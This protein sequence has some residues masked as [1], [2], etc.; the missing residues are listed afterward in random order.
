[1]ARVDRPADKKEEALRWAA[2][3]PPGLVEEHVHRLDN[4]Y[5]IQFSLE[6][7]RFHLRRIAALGKDEMLSLELE[8]V[9]DGAMLLTL[10]ADDLP[11]FFSS[12]SGI[13]TSLDFDIRS[14]KVF[15][16]DPLP[17]GATPRPGSRNLILD[18]LVLGHP[19]AGI[20]TPAFKEVLTGELLTLATRLKEKRLH[21]VREDLY[22]RIGDYL[23]RHQAAPEL[24]RPPVE[25]QIWPD[26]RHTVLH[27]Q[28]TDRKALLFSLSNA[29]SLQGVSI[30]KLI[31]YSR[32]EAFD[33]HIFVTGMGGKPITDPAS[34]ERLKVAI[35]LME[36]FTSTLPQASD[37]AAAVQSFNG[38]IDALMEKSG[39]TPDLKAF[40]DFT[41]LSALARLLG[42]GP[43]LWEEMLKLPL[44]PV[45]KL[46]SRL[47]EERKPMK[48]EALSMQLRLALSEA[49][50]YAA[51]VAALNRFKELNIFRLEA[52]QAVFPHKTLEEQG[53][54]VS[55]LAD[56][57]L[58]EALALAWDRLALEYG[59]PKVEMPTGARLGCAY[60]LAAQ[61][62]LGGRELGYA[63]DLELQLVYAGAGETAGGTHADGPVS[64]AIFFGKL[65]EELRGILPARNE[66]IFELDLR[67]RPHG[68]DGPLASNLET[69]KDYYRPG[70]GAYDYEKQA[71]LKLRP[72]VA[73][74]E[75]AETLMAARD[76][77]VF[78][79]MP[80]GIAHTLELR[81]KQIETLAGGKPKAA[82]GASGAGG[83]RVNAK[84]SRGG[85][86]EVEY[87]VQFLQLAH[88]RKYPSLR[89]ANTEKA[90][91][92]LLEEGI[93]APAE[94]EK[95]FKAYVFLRRL[96]NALR[97][98]RGHSR[99]LVVPARGSEA[100]LFLAKR[101]GYL[102]TERYAVDSQLDWDLR[103]AL[104]DV[105]AFFNA[106]FR[107]GAEGSPAPSLTDSLTAAF[108]DPEAP[109]DA[110]SRALE[111]FGL[112]PGGRGPALI[113]GI[114][115]R[116]REK[117][118]L[119]AVLVM[120]ET[121]LR[122]APDPESILVRLGQYLEAVGDPDYFVRQM[123]DHPRLME[124]LIKVFGHSEY[125][126]QI[127][128]RQP[129]YLLD[130]ASTGT[131]EKPKQPEEYRREIL[132]ST[133]P[134]SSLEAALESMRRYRNREYL[135]IGLR[136]IFLAEPLQ[137]LTAEISH[138]SNALVHAVFGWTLGDADAQDLRDAVCVI[139]LGKLGGNELN[140]S[141]DIDVVFIH[142]P[143]RAG[144]GG[145]ETLER[146]AQGFMR[147][148]SAPGANG[149]MFRVDAQLRPWGGQS[150]LVGTVQSY[151]D[152]YGGP[153]DGWELQSWLKAR[154][155]VGN[156]EMGRDLV[157]RIQAVTTS[158]ENLSKVTASMRKVRLLGLEKLKQED[159]L[160]SEVKLGPGGI[161]TIEFYVQY[162]QV[163]HGRDLPELVTGNSLAALGKL[164][165]YRLI[166]ASM[167][168]TLSRS[169]VFLRRIE[170]ALQLQG[171]Q[172]RHA[173]PDS[174][175]EL[176]KLA[177]RMGFEER[178]GQSAAEQ[179]RERYRR[180]MLTLQELS[181]ELFGYDTNVP[182][183]D[184]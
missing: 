66:G 145:R 178:L 174:P 8:P 30:Q 146:W 11:G 63:S 72:V 169:Y 68:K 134:G 117:G 107:P 52:V 90:L 5:F 13:L 64:N 44:E 123:L 182:R 104:R 165:R 166:S 170:H 176:E 133:P 17:P 36:R 20:L 121:K 88:G 71:L 79:D 112:S 109:P 74:P 54:A 127:L 59:P 153:A 98:A 97:M 96:I 177:R 141:S 173:L 50:D 113:R 111:R 86:V 138:L 167:H 41:L 60:A 103:H 106:R 91:G 23:S 16:Y 51:R 31:T 75:F 70:G 7:I 22:R 87:A 130:L 15:T 143:V 76:A 43:Y 135:R 155:L 180:H 129:D 1:M 65:V 175:E 4:D 92:L 154:A 115:E 147:A 35:V 94:F 9:G 139:A 62:K 99:D 80:V 28:G 73:A 116:S 32:G 144:A 158:P 25:I 81:E 148:L 95:L 163:L 100:F 136:D 137:R 24:D 172:Q 142:D 34:L 125:L 102:P 119:C 46:L 3:F 118:F 152:Y 93:L 37:Y 159:R 42:A 10:I 47:D 114:L 18:A 149:K 156:L 53:G 161:R 77:V 162:Q 157:R 78:G 33:D 124:M 132:E 12:L 61:G 184:S 38:F 120:A 14:G 27:I 26:E 2:D 40:E 56:A 55:D 168:D 39:G 49:D 58:A 105:H 21:E 83:E 57:L 82:A 164:W 67:L 181:S 183:S 89:T 171:M 131:L 110:A 19:D 101:M 108:L 140:Y 150:P 48:R 179:F 29:L 126:T 84:F 6:E 128:L 151:L 45:F 69:W 122:V 160:S 85:L